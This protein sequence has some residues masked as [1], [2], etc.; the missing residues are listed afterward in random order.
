VLFCLRLDR[1]S[2]CASAPS[3]YPLPRPRRRCTRFEFTD[4]THTQRLRYHY[5]MLAQ[6]TTLQSIAPAQGSRTVAMP[7]QGTRR[8]RLALQKAD[9]PIPAGG[10]YIGQEHPADSSCPPADGAVDV[11][12]SARLRHAAA[13]HNTTAPQRGR[14]VGQLHQGRRGA[15]SVSVHS[16]GGRGQGAAASS[17]TG[18]A[19]ALP[20]SCCMHRLAAALHSVGLAGSRVRIVPRGMPQQI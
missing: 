17:F 20:V 1:A 3:G 12:R 14:H 13:G 16:Q 11:D 6:K 10:Q 2:L 4:G 7:L 15:A 19:S 8:E 5:I 18:A 9:R